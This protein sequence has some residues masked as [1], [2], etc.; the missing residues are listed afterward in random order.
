MFQVPALDF[1]L[2]DLPNKT[3]LVLSVL[4]V[5]IKKDPRTFSGNDYYYVHYE[6]FNAKF[7]EWIGISQILT[8]QAEAKKAKA[9]MYSSFV[10]KKVFECVTGAFDIGFSVD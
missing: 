8:E 5:T 6:H 3:F 4:V 9:T 7:E 10:L 1:L 2:F